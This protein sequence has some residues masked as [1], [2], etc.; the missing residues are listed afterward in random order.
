MRTHAG[1]VTIRCCLRPTAT[2]SALCAALKRVH[3]N[4][5][6]ALE[7]VSVPGELP[8][9]AVLSLKRDAKLVQG[10]ERGFR[11]QREHPRTD[12]A[13]ERQ[14]MDDLVLATRC[15]GIVLGGQFSVR[16]TKHE[17]SVRWSRRDSVGDEDQAV[18]RFR[19]EV[20]TQAILD[21]LVS[22]L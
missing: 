7:L 8:I 3:R 14:L 2:Y 13:I 1:D 5:E 21:E 22:A 18:V 12:H 17:I 20:W 10:E 9:E 15:E 16:A 4:V 19:A 11:N 6:G